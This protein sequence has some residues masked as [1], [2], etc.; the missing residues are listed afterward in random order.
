MIWK[1]GKGVDDE[2]TGRVGGGA[3]RDRGGW[4][5]GK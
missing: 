3:G 1:S 5:V 4:V 2:V